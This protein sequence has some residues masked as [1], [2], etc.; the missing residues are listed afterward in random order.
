MCEYCDRVD[1]ILAAAIGVFLFNGIGT[2][3]CCVEK[4]FFT[5]EGTIFLRLPDSGKQKSHGTR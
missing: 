4:V 2:N 1:K 5:L 3:I